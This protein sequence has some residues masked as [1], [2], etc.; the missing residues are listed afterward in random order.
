[1]TAQEM[2]QLAD[3]LKLF[4]GEDFGDLPA[5]HLG[6]WSRFNLRGI[7]LDAELAAYRK[8]KSLLEA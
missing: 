6:D 7:V 1:M 2:K 8:A 3:L 5:Y 4:E